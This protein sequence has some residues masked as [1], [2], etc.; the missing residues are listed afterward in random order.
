MVA[1]PPTGRPSKSWYSI[2]RELPNKGCKV[3]PST[4]RNTARD[5]QPPERRLLYQTIAEHFEILGMNSPVPVISLAFRWVTN[6]V[7]RNDGRVTDG[8]QAVTA[9][10]SI[11]LDKVGGDFASASQQ[12]RR[13]LQGNATRLADA[14]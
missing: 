11:G 5:A 12:A 10:I 6:F 1:S 14:A 3:P 7:A 4:R 13:T 9:G 8:A 2:H